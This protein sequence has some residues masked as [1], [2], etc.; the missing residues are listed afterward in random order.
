[1]I[2]EARA[3]AA[4]LQA[5]INVDCQFRL[6]L[7]TGWLFHWFTEFDFYHCVY[8]ES[9]STLVQARVWRRGGGRR[10]RLPTPGENIK[11]WGGKSEIL[12]NMGKLN[13]KC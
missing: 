8:N 7:N 9:L 11:H 4:R 10:E 13:V 5:T 12:V 6:G 2:R 3:M 1:M